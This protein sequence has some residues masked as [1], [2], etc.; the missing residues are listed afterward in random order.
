MDEELERRFRKLAMEVYGYG[1]GSLSRA[2]EEAIRMWVAGW[3]EA[4]GVEV[5]KDPVET[6]RGLLKGVG[7]SGVELQHEAR[8]IRAEKFK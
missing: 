5:P 3:E 7:K 8:R 4:V 1:R 2:I 6:I